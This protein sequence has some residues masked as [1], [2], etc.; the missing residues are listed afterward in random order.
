MYDYYL[1]GSHNFAADRQ[2]A[3][4]TVRVW[5]DVKHLARANR[6]FLRRAVH[7][8]AGAGVNQFLD[9]GAGIPT[10]G[11]V[12]ETARSANRHAHTVYVDADLVAVAHGTA[13]LADDPDTAVVHADLRNPSTVLGDAAATGLLD[14]SRPVAVLMLAVLPF[15]PDSD[16]P[17]GI[18]AGY[19][20]ATAAGSFLVISHGTSDYRPE[21]AHRAED[22]YR[23]AAQPMTLRS[24]AQIGALLTGYELLEPGLVDMIHWRSDPQMP[25]P[26]NGDVTRYSMLAA[27]G[28]KPV[29]P[30]RGSR[31]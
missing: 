21:A 13:L 9:L 22:V 15:I 27:L 28:R 3:E 1:G 8:L 31:P 11:A 6:A 5:P 4:E 30:S 20:D 23:R 16:D 2:L 17:A 18:V 26:L 14:L 12:H 29:N 25:D 19:R 10:V 7:A 24:R